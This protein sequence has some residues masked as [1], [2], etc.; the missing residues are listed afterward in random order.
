M[1]Q[2]RKRMDEVNNSDEEKSGSQN[3]HGTDD[4]VD[5]EEEWGGIADPL[6]VDYEGEYIDEDKHTTV[7][8]EEVHLS[9]TDGLAGIKGDDDEDR[10]EG[11]QTN[12]DDKSTN[13]DK[14]KAKTKIRTK[15]DANGPMKKKKR[16]FTYENKAERKQTRLKER[17][18]SRKHAKAR[19]S[20]S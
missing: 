9:R 11:H 20:K 12:G 15:E 18:G 17:E 16:K 4:A 8:V 2:H 1:V 14:S 3:E 13:G 7:T 10:E 6:P 5:Q 19:R